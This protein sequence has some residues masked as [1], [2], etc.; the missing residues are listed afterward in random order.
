MK[1]HWLVL[2]SILLFLACG[3]EESTTYPITFKYSNEVYPDSFT[4]Y[5]FDNDLMAERF[6]PQ[7]SSVDTLY[8]YL[9]SNRAP[10]TNWLYVDHEF[11]TTIFEQTELTFVSDNE[12]QFTSIVDGEVWDTTYNYSLSGDRVIIGSDSV[13]IP[14]DWTYSEGSGEFIWNYWA[15]VHI[16]YSELNGQVRRR[17]SPILSTLD[18][19]EVGDD[20]AVIDSWISQIEPG[21][22]LLVGYGQS[23]WVEE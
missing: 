21:D 3:D 8:A 13:F 19:I 9:V 15:G 23:V 6:D 18:G 14:S 12:L 2:V 10:G 11:N 5:A 17:E 7:G 22:T 4:C 1:Q 16:D 20:A